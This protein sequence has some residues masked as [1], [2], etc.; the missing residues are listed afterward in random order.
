MTNKFHSELYACIILQRQ[1]QQNAA[2]MGGL[3]REI[4]SLTVW[5]LEVQDQ[6]AGRAGFSWD[7]SPWL[8]FP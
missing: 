8:A 1:L 4:Y 5:N 6:S 3:R 7:S 2:N